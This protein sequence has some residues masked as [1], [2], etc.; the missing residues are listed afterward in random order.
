MVGID[1][2]SEGLGRRF[3]KAVIKK[4]GTPAQ[5][6]ATRR[7]EGNENNTLGHS[8]KGTQTQGEQTW[9]TPQPTHWGW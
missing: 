9:T 4:K 5:L 2:Q 6:A 8:A 7:N 3:A 1:Q